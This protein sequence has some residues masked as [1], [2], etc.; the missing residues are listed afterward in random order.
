MQAPTGQSNSWVEAVGGSQHWTSHG[1]DNLW[2][3]V[4]P[5]TSWY[6]HNWPSLHQWMEQRRHGT[7][8]ITQHCVKCIILFMCF[9]TNIVVVSNIL[10]NCFC[11]CRDCLRFSTTWVSKLT[12]NWRRRFLVSA[13]LWR[14]SKKM[15]LKGMLQGRRRGMRKRRRQRRRYPAPRFK[16][17]YRTSS[18]SLSPLNFCHLWVGNIIGVSISRFTV[19]LTPFMKSSGSKFL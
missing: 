16:V 17:V 3:W 1:P 15:L 13:R 8:L 18:S 7:F 19:L 2:W 10:V 11:L 14:R 12:P 5:W 9:G 4:V 6:V